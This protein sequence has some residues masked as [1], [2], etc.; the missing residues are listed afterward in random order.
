MVSYRIPI[1]V[2]RSN[3]E[4]QCRRNWLFLW[5]WR[6]TW[7]S[8]KWEVTCTHRVYILSHWSGKQKELKF[9]GNNW[10]ASLESPVMV[11]SHGSK[12]WFQVMVPASLRVLLLWWDNQRS[13]HL[14]YNDNWSN[15]W[16]PLNGFGLAYAPVY[17]WIRRVEISNLPCD[18]AA[19]YWL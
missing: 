6:W 10:L 15:W 14:L 7:K 2:L 12:S 8:R 18:M 4:R 9:V 5:S 13:H 17:N 1:V 16:M 3:A 11:P 19:C